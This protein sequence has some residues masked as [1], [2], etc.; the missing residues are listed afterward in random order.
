MKLRNC[1][2]QFVMFVSTLIAFGANTS[3]QSLSSFTRK[4]TS[5]KDNAFVLGLKA[6]IYGLPLLETNRASK[7]FFN[8]NCTSTKFGYTPANVFNY[9]EIVTSNDSYITSPNVDVFYAPVKLNLAN[10]PVVIEHPNMGNRY[11]SFQITDPYGNVIDYVGSRTTGNNASRIAF[12]WKFDN[13]GSAG[14]THMTNIKKIIKLDYSDM[15]LVGRFLVVDDEDER[16]VRILLREFKLIPPGGQI[17]VPPCD[18]N[19]R[20]K[21]YK[22]PSGLAYYTELNDAIKLYPPPSRD[23]K[24]MKELSKIGVGIYSDGFPNT[25]ISSAQV[26]A[27]IKANEYLLPALETGIRLRQVTSKRKNDGWIVP[28]ANVGDY[29][30]DYLTRAFVT[31]VGILANTEEEALYLPAF[32]D[33]KAQ[34]LN[35]EKTYRLTFPPGTEPPV[36]QFWSLTLYNSDYLLPANL[37]EPIH[38][39]VSVK[40]TFVRQSDGTVVIQMSRERPKDATVNWLPTPLSTDPFY[41]MLRCYNP[42]RPIL[43]RNWTCPGINRVTIRDRIGVRGGE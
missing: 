6:S 40:S 32:Y 7:S 33:R 8:A 3:Q 24:I 29:G 31:I 26:M 2:Q 39:V 4:Y 27:I 30:V 10:G 9:M 12:K 15:I 42:R 34:R 1:Q 18:A 13:S 16:A 41:V 38:S 20:F 5:G 25:N 14:Q 21:N 35:S 36:D 43:L 17:L 28:P 19:T 22:I 23:E 37:R 11:F